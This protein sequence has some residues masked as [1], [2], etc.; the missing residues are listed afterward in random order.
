MKSIVAACVLLSLTLGAAAA[1]EPPA[2]G[3][4]GQQTRVIK[5]LSDAEIADLTTGAGAGLARAAELNGY[6]GP[7]HVLELAA[8][9]R[10]DASQHEASS[11][12]MAGHRARAREIGAALVTAEAELDRLFAQKH[13]DIATVDRATERVGLLQAR[14]RAEHLKTHLVQTALL[15]AEQV[16][17]YAELRGY[18]P[19]SS[20]A[21]RNHAPHGT[22]DA[23][24]H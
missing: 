9:L 24:R 3:Y 20:E 22:R 16:R 8:P 1:A 7:A 4:A 13:A 12:L 17:L 10:L 2:G 15:S 18:S 6:P 21:P 19:G 23:H 14:L 5:S 11:R